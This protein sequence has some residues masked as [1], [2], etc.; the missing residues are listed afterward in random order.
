MANEISL[1]LFRVLQEA[2]QNVVKHSGVRRFTLELRGNLGEIQL[3]VVISELG[4]TRKTP[5]TVVASDSSV[6]RREC[7]W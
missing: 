2:L 1:C 3:S 7:N 4:L 5:S 6:C